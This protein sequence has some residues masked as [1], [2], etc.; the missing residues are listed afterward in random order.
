MRL[1]GGG[2][3]GLSPVFLSGLVMDASAALVL[4]V[5]LCA[6]WLLLR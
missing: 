3:S 1:A 6:L 5:A 4:F 2:P